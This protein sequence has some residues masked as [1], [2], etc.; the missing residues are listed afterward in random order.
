MGRIW[1]HDDPT[2]PPTDLASPFTGYLMGLRTLPAV[3]RGQSLALIG[4]AIERN[5]LLAES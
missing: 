1:S 5:A 2:R 4:R 3:E